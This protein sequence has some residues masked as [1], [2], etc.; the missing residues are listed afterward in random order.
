MPMFLT[1]L[2][3][4]GAEPQSLGELLDTRTARHGALAAG[5]YVGGEPVS[6][7]THGAALDDPFRVGSVSKVVTALS[8]LQLADAGLVDLDAPLADQLPGFS[9]GTFEQG[10]P[11]TP[12]HVLSHHAGLPSDLLPGMFGHD[13][14]P[15]ASRTA[16]LA[17]EFATHAPPGWW[18]YS[19]TGYTVLG[20]LIE[21]TSGQPYADYVEEH[22]LAPCGMADSSFDLATSLQPTLKGEP[23]DEGD[24]QTDSPAGGLVSTVPDLV[25]LARALITGT[26][27]GAPIVSAGLLAQMQTPQHVHPLDFDLRVGLGLELHPDSGALGGLDRV[28][29]DGDTIASHARLAWLPEIDAVAVALTA[30][31]EAGGDASAF[32]DAALEQ[33]AEDALGWDVPGVTSAADGVAGPNPYTRDELRALEGTYGTQLG[34]FDLRRRGRGLRG[35]LVGHEVK[36]VPTPSGTFR[37]R[38][39]VLGVVLPF[40]LGD[41]EVKFAQ[42]DG[43]SALAIRGEGISRTWSP[44]GSRFAASAAEGRWAERL[45]RWVPLDNEDDTLRL[46]EVR[47]EEEDGL[48]R[49]V[50]VLA[51]PIET[52]ELSYGLEVLDERLARTGGTGRRAG[53][54]VRVEAFDGE[55]VLV[56]QGT[57]L[58]FEG[59]TRGCGCSATSGAHWGATSLVLVG[60]ALTAT[61]RGGSA[62]RRAPSPPGRR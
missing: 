37:I 62:R 27:A 50:T 12:R 17:D 33:A 39:V 3:A 34:L 38:P 11:I 32:V 14:P 48:L 9:I 10:P 8:V 43:R 25:R 26:C 6:T 30:E 18:S 5:L 19:N 36:L 2:L 46:E 24:Q 22:V 51:D 59:P 57:A 20:H 13:S 41:M 21:E 42:V 15:I 55:E 35:E 16:Q 1:A 31:A 49:M 40:Q 47:L 28:G 56:V 52:L 4:C 58:S 53:E 61:R 23:L 54:A 7:H 44:L 45:G 29:H 60:C